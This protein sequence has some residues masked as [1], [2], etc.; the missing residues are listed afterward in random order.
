MSYNKL[1]C[2]FLIIMRLVRLHQ[3]PPQLPLCYPSRKLKSLMLLIAFFSFPAVTSFFYL[4]PSAQQSHTYH[5]VK[6]EFYLEPRI[7][8]LTNFNTIPFLCSL[9]NCCLYFFFSHNSSIA[10]VYFQ[11]LQNSIRIYRVY[12][13]TIAYPFNYH[14]HFYKVWEI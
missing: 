9:Y 1:C 8:L 12:T 14:Y 10:D 11:R 6:V 5:P 3:V 4:A 7:G 2:M 13:R